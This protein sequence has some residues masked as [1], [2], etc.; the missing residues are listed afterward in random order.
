MVAFYPACRKPFQGQFVPPMSHRRR[1]RSD[2]PSDRL[3]PTSAASGA[4][5][6]RC[7]SEGRSGQRKTGKVPVYLNVYD[8]TPINV[9]A[10]WL[11]LGVYHSGVQGL[12]SVVGAVHGVE[13]AYGAHEHATTGIFEGEPRQCPGFVFRKSILIGRTD[14]GQREVRA[15]ME[16][17]ATEYTGNT[18]NLISK[19]CNHFCNKACLRLTNKPI[20]RWVN[21]L[22]RIGFLCNCV[23]PVQ[24]AAVRSRSDE[25]KGNREGD[26]RKLR[27]NS[28]RFPPP[29]TSS[30]T[31]APPI[32]SVPSS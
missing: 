19:N 31:T 16:E 18:Y 21:R 27:S 7:S 25:A 9:Y 13:Y 20:P 24:V 6:G 5:A 22:A 30:S 29:T 10:Y 1:P 26:R 14:L 32:S 28:T 4:A 23:L 8:L 17:L 15:L 3:H 11:G 2:P 12:G